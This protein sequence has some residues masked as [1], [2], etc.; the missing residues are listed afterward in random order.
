MQNPSDEPATPLPGTPLPLTVNRDRGRQ[1][2]KHCP[3]SAHALLEASKREATALALLRKAQ[4]GRLPHLVALKYERMA[5]SP[6]GYLRGAVPVMAWD[7]GHAAHTGL[8]VQLCGDAH[9]R[10]FGA[11]ASP[12]GSL[13]FD[14][15][16]FDET[17]RGP[18]EWDLKRMATS[19][20]LAGREAGIKERSCKDAVSALLRRYQKTIRVLAGLPILETARYQVRR[21]NTADPL[22]SVFSKAERATPLHNLQA[23]TEL[24]TAPVTSTSSSATAADTEH[25]QDATADA[26]V[27]AGGAARRFCNQ[28]PLLV[29]LSSAEAAPVL[30][31]LP[32]YARTLQ[33]ERRHFLAGY[34]ALEVAFKVVG[35][36]SVGLRDYCIYMQGNGPDDPLFLQIKEEVPSGWSPYVRAPKSRV[37]HGKRVV[38]GQRAMQLQSD[39]FLGYTTIEGRDYLVRQLNDHKASI[40]PD[41]FT[42]EAL[43]HYADLCGELLARG[44]ARSAQ[45]ALLSGYMGKGSVFSA[46]IVEFAALYADQTERDWQQLVRSRRGKAKPAAKSQGGGE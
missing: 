33:P 5:A 20:L 6:F 16:D 19:I 7:L 11:Y 40:D 27:A 37:H 8:M 35:T 13:V 29:P 24:Y 3:R 25:T 1:V 14:I 36:G 41:T 23:L 18:F 26:T 17:I 44:H 4:Q 22:G 43:T 10:N 28:A 38:D 9:V 32:A 45:A 31:S 21:V 12:D 30:A 39:P 42:A 46:A 2:R 15:N 34:R